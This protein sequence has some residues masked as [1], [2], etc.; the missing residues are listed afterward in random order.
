VWGH[1][2]SAALYLLACFGALAG[3]GLATVGIWQFYGV[4]SP[5]ESNPLLL[6]GSGLLVAAGVLF[7]GAVQLHADERNRAYCFLAE[8][9][10]S[11]ELLRATKYIGSFRNINGDMTLD[12]GILI[13]TTEQKECKELID[14]ISVAC[15]F[16]EEMA[17]AV[18][19]R[20]INEFIVREVYVGLLFRVADFLHPILPVLRN[21]P[22]ISGHQYGRSKPEVYEHM[23]WLY[24][25]WAP[26]Y[27]LIHLKQSPPTGLWGRLTAEKEIFKRRWIE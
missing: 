9:I 11:K 12:R 3:V 22:P 17:V 27:R 10:N 18:R 15:N 4:E 14:S 2:H 19:S 25:R 21:D 7:S 5:P 1:T 24:G 16:F 23:F 20:Q 6:L 8:H 26:S 13:F